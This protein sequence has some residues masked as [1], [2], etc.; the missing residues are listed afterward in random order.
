MALRVI[1]ATAPPQL[2][3]RLSK[4]SARSG[5]GVYSA[6][7]A[8]LN[9][10]VHIALDEMAEKKV[11]VNTVSPG[12]IQTPGLDCVAAPEAVAYLTSTTGVQRVGTVEEIAGT[13]L[14]LAS[15]A[16]AYV[17][18]AEIAVDGGFIQYHLK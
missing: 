2:H 17:N 7:R 11:R 9:K 8:A 1:V 3:G 10:I 6:T 13:V 5:I 18:W 16:A 4:M 15:D 14:F 12:P